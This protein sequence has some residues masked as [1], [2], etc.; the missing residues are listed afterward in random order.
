MLCRFASVVRTL[1]NY[2]NKALQAIE[3]ENF[4]IPET[5]FSPLLRGNPS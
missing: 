1:A 3:T 4:D 2:E 5:E